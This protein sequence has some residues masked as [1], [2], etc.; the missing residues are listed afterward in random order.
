MK[1]DV[2]MSDLNRRRITLVDSNGYSLVELLT[3]V[4]IIGV[5]LLGLSSVL[6]NLEESQSRAVTQTT[7]T[8]MRDLFQQTIKNSESWNQTVLDAAN[9]EMA[10]LRNRTACNANVWNNLKLNYA[11]GTTAFDGTVPTQG[12]SPAGI[13][14][15]T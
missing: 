6:S 11:D 5:V 9:V 8:Q 10:C 14:C 7:F 12:I 1:Q 2:D 13:L 15:N 4:S 3:V